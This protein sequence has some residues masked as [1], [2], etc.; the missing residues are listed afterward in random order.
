MSD[1]LN[2]GS[3]ALSESQ[4]QTRLMDWTKQPSVRGQYPDLK[5]LFHIPNERPDKIQAALLKRMGVKPGVPDVFLPVPRGGYHGLWIE[6]K[7]DGGKPSK[8]QR[9]WLEYLNG[10]GYCA[11]LCYGWQ[12]AQMEIEKYMKLPEGEKHG[13]L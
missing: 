6:L 10:A 5:Y 12:T 11:L 4:E 9:D 3:A 2:T 13:K 7:V 8:E 1:T